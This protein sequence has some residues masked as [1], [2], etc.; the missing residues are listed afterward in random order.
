M[1]QHDLPEKELDE[2]LHLTSVDAVAT[3]GVDLNGCSDAILKKVPAITSKLAH[4]I[5]QARPFTQ[6]RDL[7]RVKGLGPKTYENCAAFV[8]VQGP[9]MLDATLVHPESYVLARWLLKQLQW[10]L[11]DPPKSSL[12][13]KTEWATVYSNIVEMGSK[14]F[15]VDQDRLLAVIENLADSK[16]H[17]DPRLIKPAEKPSAGSVICCS[18]LSQ[19]Q[20]SD[21]QNICPIR[22]VIGTAR[23]ICDFGVYVDFGGHKDGLLHKSKLGPVKLDSFLIGQE[24]GVDLLSID[25][26]G[27][28]SLAL[29]GLGLEASSRLPTNH[30]AKSSTIRQGK[31]KQA[32]GGSTNVQSKRRKTS[33]SR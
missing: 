26:Q 23:N 3:V 9:E 6:R 15:D 25:E 16:T 13:P 33:S 14:E 1:Y 20:L 31:R 7:L 17:K 18:M 2:K 32:G 10:T 30:N 29:T 11:A 19:E 22:G 8:R 12:P 21:I 5:L 4:E 27:K 24:I 28:V